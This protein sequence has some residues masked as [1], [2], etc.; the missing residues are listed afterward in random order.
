MWP[1]RATT[2]INNNIGFMP[3][4]IHHHCGGGFGNAFKWMLGFNMAQNMMTSLFSAFKPQSYMQMTPYYNFTSTPYYMP[5]MTPMQV[6]TMSTARRTLDS[7]GFTKESGYSVSMGEDGK[8]T[9]TY[10]DGTTT[11][12]ASNL[13]E[14]LNKQAAARQASEE[15]DNWFVASEGD[16]T[17]VVDDT[18]V[19][20]E[21]PESETIADSAL[22][23]PY[24]N[25]VSRPPQGWYRAQNAT[26]TTYRFTK[27][28]LTAHEGAE[29][30]VDFIVKAF[31]AFKFGDKEINKAVLRDAII[32]NNPSVFDEDGNLKQGADLSKLDNPTYKW[33]KENATQQ[34][35]IKTVF[36][37][38]KDGTKI[39]IKDGKRI[40]YINNK[41]CTEIDFMK[42]RP[43][44]FFQHD[45]K[46]Y[47]EETLPVAL[48]LYDKYIG[49]ELT[50]TYNAGGSPN[51]AH[52]KN[53]IEKIDYV[54]SE[55]NDVVI[56]VEYDDCRLNDY[57]YMTYT[58]QNCTDKSVHKS[59]AGIYKDV[60]SLWGQ[61]YS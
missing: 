26:S 31:N 35:S 39:E 22:R 45:P 36:E 10:T 18:V 13:K 58:Y 9:Y 5:G 52:R 27:E 29:T 2:I 40:Y 48:K 37:N 8:L 16:E 25:R 46:V 20:D 11:I 3:P 59:M 30:S 12:T 14:L 42:Q 7:L 15:D 61:S 51:T 24:S 33:I 21:T 44:T 54:K 41:E 43:V 32:K 1:T 4:R 6:D 57:W 53:K 47:N 60:M 28:Q 23:T 19:V 17:V 38:P 55:G 56:H 49:A 34:A 50:R